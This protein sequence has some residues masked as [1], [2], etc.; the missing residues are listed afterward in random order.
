ML[1]AGWAGELFA[2]VSGGGAY[3]FAKKSINADRASRFET[4]MKKKAQLAAIEAEDRRNRP[5]SSGSVR[6]NMARYQSA[7]DDVAS[8]SEEAGHDPAP[9]RHEPMTEIDRVVEKGKYEAA[10]PFRPPKGNRL[11]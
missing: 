8:P 4:E 3:Y 9:T 1:F 7:T 10:Q 6:A 5:E 2:L 11:S